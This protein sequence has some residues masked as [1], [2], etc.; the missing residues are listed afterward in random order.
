MFIFCSICLIICAWILSLSTYTYSSTHT[1]NPHWVTHM[2]LHFLTNWKQV[3]GI[4]PF[5]P[6][7]I[8]MFPNN[9]LILY[10]HRKFVHFRR[11]NIDTIT[12]SHSQYLFKFQMSQCLPAIANLPTC[13]LQSSFNKGS[14]FICNYHVSL[15][16]FNLKHFLHF[17][18][19]FF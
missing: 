18:L 4:A 13:H 5:Y 9:K 8:S 12:L 2:Y 15:G 16:S 10:N 19:F 6:E 11:F 14:H 3:A 1:H 17:G 7:H